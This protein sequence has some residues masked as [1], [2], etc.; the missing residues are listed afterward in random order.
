MYALIVNKH[1]LLMNKSLMLLDKFGI[2]NVLCKFYNS[3]KLLRINFIYIR[4]AQ[5]FQPF[6]NGLYFEVNYQILYFFFFIKSIFFLKH[7]GRKY[8][9]RDFQMLFAPCCAEC[10][11][12]DYK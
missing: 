9:E 3:L 11:K 8:C 2:Q 4:C 12:Y 10:S 6:E 5:C 7:E 1:L